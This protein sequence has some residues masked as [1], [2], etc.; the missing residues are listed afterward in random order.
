M[1]PGMAPV[2]AKGWPGNWHFMSKD[3]TFPKTVRLKKQQD[4][5]RVFGEEH[6]AADQ[7]LVIR[8]RRNGLEHCRLGLSVGRK[9]GNAVVRN[10]WKRT[11]REAFRKQKADL[12]ALD[13]VVRPRKGSKCEYAGLFDSLNKLCR[14]LNKK[15]PL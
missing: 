9:V 1:L 7:Y 15:I 10:Q 12:P 14:R 11:I 2:H 3:E 13:I 4:F 5:D 8:A 6:F